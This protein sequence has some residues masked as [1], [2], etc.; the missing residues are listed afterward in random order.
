MLGGGGGVWVALEA[1]ER[2]DALIPVIVGVVGVVIGAVLAGVAVVAAFMDQAF[3]RKLR[4][5]KKEP[6]RYVRPFLFT[7]WLGTVCAISASVLTAIPRDTDAWVRA[8]ISGFTGLT[9]F[10]TL[11]SVIPDLDMLVQFIGLK[12]DASEIPDDAVGPS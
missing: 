12:F 2:I 6:V 8:P 10:W 1:P 9:A 5:I 7:A 4:A 11:G 3:L